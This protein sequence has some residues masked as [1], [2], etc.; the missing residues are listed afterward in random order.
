[1][2]HTNQVNSGR[3]LFLKSI[4]ILFSPSM[5][6]DYEV[7]QKSHGTSRII[8]GSPLIKKITWNGKYTLI[9]KLDG[10]CEIQGLH[11]FAPILI[12]NCSSLVFTKCSFFI[13]SEWT[14]HENSPYKYVKYYIDQD[15]D[16]EV[17]WVKMFKSNGLKLNKCTFINR[18]IQYEY[19]NVFPFWNG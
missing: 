7:E 10:F 19:P 11:I 3:R 1:M 6:Y 14:Y 13:L 5:E 2:E 16:K 8:I 4:P 12:K 18:N 17:Y 15:T 9:E